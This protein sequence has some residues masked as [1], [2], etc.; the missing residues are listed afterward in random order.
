MSI[1]DGPDPEKEAEEQRGDEEVET[2]LHGGHR[3]LQMDAK[4]APPMHAAAIAVEHGTV[5]PPT[6][7]TAAAAQFVVV[8]RQRVA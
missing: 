3:L 2:R 4:A 6:V 1:E 8:R 5:L 7:I